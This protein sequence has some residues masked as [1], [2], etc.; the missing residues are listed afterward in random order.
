MAASGT[1]GAAEALAGG[2]AGRTFGL[3]AAV[4]A[5]HIRLDVGGYQAGTVKSYYS[6]RDQASVPGCEPVVLVASRL[7][8]LRRLAGPPL[9]E[10][11]TADA[12]R[13]W[14]H[15]DV[16]PSLEDELGHAF[17]LAAA[18]SKL[19]PKSDTQR[20]IIESYY[21]RYFDLAAAREVLHRRY[22][23]V[24]VVAGGVGTPLARVGKRSECT[25]GGLASISP[26]TVEELFNNA[27]HEH[28]DLASRPGMDD[29]R[30]P[31]VFSPQAS[32]VLLHEVVGHLVEAD[33]YV[34]GRD[35][36][37]GL[38][39]RIAP[40]GSGLTV[41][42]LAPDVGCW[43]SAQLDDEG[44]PARETLLVDDGYVTGLLT[45]QRYAK[46]S[47][48]TS[49]GHGRASWPDQKVIPRLARLSM[50]A[51]DHDPDELR[52]SAGA[53]IHVDNIAWGRMNPRTRQVEL[54]LGGV[55]RLGR[56]GEVESY[57]GGV[58]AAGIDSVLSQLRGVASDRR[59]HPSL[60]YKQG[61]GLP[62]ETA[63]PTTY[64]ADLEI[65]ALAH[66]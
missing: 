12:E 59:W 1:R 15:F 19:D 46:L 44:V 32:G 64:F 39:E 30:G 9:K 61:Q 31:V 52:E 55:R 8:D 42:D 11:G 17:E 49:T 51:G 26:A 33:N 53:H 56:D 13:V 36:A 45:S 5:Y 43:G 57:A 21:Y 50:T 24:S 29:Y 22:A 35:A 3:P 18:V 16:R 23:R 41:R 6:I 14:S 60:C 37:Q 58:I 62:V 7:E 10:F 27:V 34:S 28:R 47:G 2:R 66:S 38:G 20:T 63:T 48:G 25:V 40:E 65:C 4:M 54:T